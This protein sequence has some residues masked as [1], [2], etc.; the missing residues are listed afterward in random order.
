[1]K[2][3]LIPIILILT[4][5]N[6]GFLMYNLVSERGSTKVAV[7]QMEQLVYQYEGMKEASES[8]S[9]K[10]VNWKSKSDTLEQIMQTLWEE[11]SLD[12]IN[13][14]SESSLAKK[15]E[16]NQYRTSYINYKNKIKE[17]AQE[18]DQM[19]TIGVLNQIR[20]HMTAYAQEED[21]D[22]II[23]NTELENI[24]YV[25][26]PVDVTSSLLKFAND[27]YQNGK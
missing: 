20:E 26:D 17:T 10:L 27:R 3:R 22:L 21:F 5:L 7:V 6:T 4:L 24:A 19:M 18:E 13:G 12:S 23:A 1:M 11:I 2:K 16:F 25:S 15:H 14:K 9:A 8:Y